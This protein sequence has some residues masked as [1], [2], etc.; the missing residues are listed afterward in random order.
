MQYSDSYMEA[1]IRVR[2][3]VVTSDC[4]QRYLPHFHY[5]LILQVEGAETEY[6]KNV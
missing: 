3:V 1:A 4:I 6:I 5:Y 2:E